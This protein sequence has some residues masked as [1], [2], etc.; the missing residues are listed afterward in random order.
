MIEVVAR[1]FEAVTGESGLEL[2]H[3]AIWNQQADRGDDGAEAAAQIQTRAAKDRWPSIPH[4]R[5]RPDLGEQRFSPGTGRPPAWRSTP[6][7]WRRARPPR[8]NGSG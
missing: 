5:P 3:H 8:A 6:A 1:E 4:G 7:K 2:G